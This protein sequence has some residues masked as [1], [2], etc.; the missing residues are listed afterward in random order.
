MILI[1]HR[2]N[3]NGSNPEWENDPSYI[4]KSLGKGFQCEVDLWVV[5]KEFWLG[6]DK[7]Q[8][9]VEYKWFYKRNKELWIHCKNKAALERFSEGN[10]GSIGSFFN[11]FWHQEDSYTITSKGYVWTY[12]GKTVTRNGICLFP[13]QRNEKINKKWGGICSDY[14]KNYSMLL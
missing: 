14:I 1:S 10:I 2:G 8:Y 12:P 3:L 7:P 4:E 5:K 9:K 13:E 6:H 11:F